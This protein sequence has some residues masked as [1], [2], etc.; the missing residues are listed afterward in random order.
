MVSDRCTMGSPAVTL[1][2]GRAV[3][4]SITLRPAAPPGSSGSASRA[5]AASSR[6]F[7]PILRSGGFVPA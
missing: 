3:T 7:A 1:A 2:G 5:R 6:S 4:L